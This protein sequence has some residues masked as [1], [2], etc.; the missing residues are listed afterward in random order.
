MPHTLT[1]AQMRE[2]DRRAIEDLG[3]PSAVLM[4]RAGKAVFDALPPGSVGIVCG[5][6]NNGGDGW[7]VARYSLLAGRDIHVVLVGDPGR[8]TP[9]AGTF[10]SVY[11]HLG[12]S[13]TLAR[14]EESAA[15]AVSALSDR[16]VLVDAVLGTGTR[17]EVQGPPRAVID[18][19][20]EVHTVAVD[21]PSGL[22]G[23]T[24]EVCG[25]CVAASTTVTFQ[26][27]KQGFENPLARQWCGDIIVADIGIPAVCGDD[28][29]WNS[30]RAKNGTTPCP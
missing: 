30:L 2:A 26:F 18:A 13:V 22:N 20:P 3:I 17:G 24:G 4:D 19:W 6:G 5:R 7:V 27:T 16:D 8:L 28:D 29:A 23:D 14:D 12:G 25:A 10:K 9:D 1:V 15:R 21:I 11:E